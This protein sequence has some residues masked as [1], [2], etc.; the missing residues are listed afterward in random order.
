MTLAARLASVQPHRSNIGCRTCMW[1]ETLSKSD[2]QAWIDWLA[3]GK[4]AQQLWEVATQEGLQ[5]S[6]TGFRH[7]MRHETAQ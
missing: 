4:S 7:H 5:I 3:E 6:L 1:L 2:R